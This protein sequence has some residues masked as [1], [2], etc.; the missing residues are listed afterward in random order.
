MR[1][2]NTFVILAV[3]A[4]IGFL[5]AGC[6]KQQAAG[7]KIVIRYAG[8]LPVNHHLTKS[9]EYFKKVVEERTSGRVEVQLFPAQQLYSDKDLVEAVPKGGVEM[10]NLSL[11]MWTGLSPSLGLLAQIGAYSDADHFHR[12]EDGAPGQEIIKDLEEKGNLKFLGWL[13][14]DNGYFFSVKPIS[15]LDDFK[16]LRM[17]GMGDFESVFI[18]GLGAAP[19]AMSSSEMYMAMQKKT[20]EGAVT[21]ATSYVERNLIEVARYPLENAIAWG[22]AFGIVVNRDFWNKLPPDVQQV[23]ADAAREVTLKSRE[24]AQK[25]NAGAWEKIKNTSGVTVTKLSAADEEKMQQIGREA[26]SKLL[27]DKLGQERAKQLLDMVEALR[28]Q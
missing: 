25:A 9:Q 6:G 18:Q 5:V 27:A 23:I 15:K 11:Y 14:F 24:E 19:V 8:T 26:G 16:G 17:R 2:R 1:F 20:I 4:L 22:G 7:E 3:V 21:G 12:V 10:A 13:D 28:K